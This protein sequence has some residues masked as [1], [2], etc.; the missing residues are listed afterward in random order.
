MITMLRKAFLVG[1]FCVMSVGSAMAADVLQPFVLAYT[2]TG[3]V[4][5]VASEVKGKLT[6]AG[7]EIV[8]EYAPYDGADIIV[9]TNDALKAN[10]AKSGNPDDDEFGGYGAIQRVSVTK[11]GDSIEVAY[12]NPVYMAAAYRMAGDLSDVRAQ[13]EKALGSEQDYG[14][15][16]DLTADD[17]RE[18]HY[19]FGMPYFD[20]PNELA[21]YDSYEDAIKAVEASLANG[22]G[23]TKKLYR[24]D[25]PGKQETVFGVAL[26]GPPDSDTCGDVFVMNT[27]DLSTPRHTPHLPYEMVVSEGNVWSLRPEFRI[28]IGWPHLAFMGGGE[29]SFFSIKCVMGSIPKVLEQAAGQPGK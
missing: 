26:L 3:E 19:S 29:G 18:Y 2:T 24:V 6:G 11:N 25:I 16:K 13:L 22:A 15:E 20:E 1:I 28:A 17:L 12:T 5:T 27:I 23:N 9:V 4:S 10:A 8:G 21:E 14:S 7:F